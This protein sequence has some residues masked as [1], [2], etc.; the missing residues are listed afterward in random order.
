MR[1]LEK[2]LIVIDPDIMMSDY[3]SEFM[4]A[5]HFKEK[6]FIFRIK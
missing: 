6:S 5:Q 3:L 1:N 4:W 2:H